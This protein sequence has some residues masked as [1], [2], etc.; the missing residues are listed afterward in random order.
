MKQPKLGLWTIV[1][2]A[3]VAVAGCATPGPVA[4]IP[5]PLPPTATPPAALP[6]TLK[7][8]QDA[9]NRHDA[10]GVLALFADPLFFSDGDMSYSA[11]DKAKLR[12]YFGHAFAIGST[13]TIKDCTLQGDAWQCSVS[14]RDDCM[15]AFA[16][17]TATP[18]GVFEPHGAL[19]ANISGGKIQ[20]MSLALT[21]SDQKI[22]DQEL[23]K[24][25]AWI[26]ANRPDDW[27]K[28]DGAPYTQELGGI[29]SQ[30]CKAYIA[31][32]K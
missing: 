15:M 17:S 23:P 14:S 7:A 21:P 6:D 16:P 30:V 29:W 20:R 24:F 26:R 2:L 28:L 5:S 3:L 9:Y 8:Y 32:R 25:L 13:I 4:V 10:E 11:G 18:V 12:G 1:T 31:G 19:K 27:S 22:F